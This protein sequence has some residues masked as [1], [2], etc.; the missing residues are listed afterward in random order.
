MV[1]PSECNAIVIT[2]DRTERKTCEIGHQEK[3]HN[4]VFE[5]NS[6]SGNCTLTIQHPETPKFSKNAEI[7]HC[8]YY[9]FYRHGFCDSPR[10]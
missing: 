5:G 4:F 6:C 8:G 1:P 2:G 9:D 10:T 7:V 3:H